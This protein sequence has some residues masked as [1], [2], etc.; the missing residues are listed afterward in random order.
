[1]EFFTLEN[2]N[3]LKLKFTDFGGIVSEIHVP[4]RDGTFADVTLGF[5]TV[6]EYQA[7]NDAYFGALIGRYGNRIG[8]GRFILDGAEFDGLF[9]NNGS[10]HLHG[11][12][13]G[14]DKVVWK[15]ELVSGDGYTGAKLSYR[16][17]DGEEGYPGN[18][19][20]SV[21]YRLTDANEWVI[22][23]EATTDAP[24]VFNPTQHAYFNLAGHA[25]PSP[26]NHEML[27][28]AKFFTPTDD[29][30]IPTGEVLGVEG[31]DFDFRVA[32]VYGES[33]DSADTRVSRL[34]GFDHN[35]ILDKQAG[36]FGLAAIAYDPVSGRELKVFTSEP[37]V[38]FYAGNFLDGSLT[39]KGGKVYNFR[40][41]F[42]LETQHFPDS[43]NH[44]HFPDTALRPGEVFRSKTVYAFGVR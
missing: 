29:G 40:D 11:G 5:A 24:T 15:V 26:L 31:T 43:P 28:N 17:V 13:L 7:R 4:D 25:G 1:M 39:G 18:L 19:D 6:E 36:A 32:K 3:G 38:Q 23:Y 20:V 21:A 44:G 37:G 41:G 8:N 34:R 30:G 10:N 42:C 12:K 27:I 22:E 9:V 33:V 2:K 14:F 35:W 16:S